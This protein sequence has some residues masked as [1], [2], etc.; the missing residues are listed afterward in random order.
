MHSPV[1][2]SV[3]SDMSSHKNS[4]RVPQFSV[5]R[6]LVRIPKTHEVW[7]YMRR[8]LAAVGVDAGKQRQKECSFDILVQMFHISQ[9]TKQIFLHFGTKI[10][11]IIEWARKRLMLVTLL[12][13]LCIS[14]SLTMH[15]EHI[16]EWKMQANRMRFVRVQCSAR[17]TVFTTRIY[18]FLAEKWTDRKWK[19]NQVRILE[20]KTSIKYKLVAGNKW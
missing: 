19:R 5:A 17:L 6:K 3:I 20:F 10:R 8:I 2:C 1:I 18:G 14:M 16:M 15:C 7:S 4:M 11:H 9:K 13:I 12:C